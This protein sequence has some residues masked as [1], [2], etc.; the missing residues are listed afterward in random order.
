MKLD[1]LAFGAHPDDVELSCSGTIIKHVK[2]GKRVG[3]VDLTRGELGSRGNAET[4]K[5]E[6]EKASEILGIC[7]RENLGYRDGFFQ[8][9][10]EHQMG[11][12]R[13]IRKYRPK[14]V[15]CNARVDRH[16]DHGRAGELVSVA[17]FLSGL[18]KVETE[19]DGKKQ[20]HW[21]PAVV[22]H[23]VQD[24]YIKPNIVIDVSPFIE[25]KMQSILAYSSQFY[26]PGKPDEEP[27][28]PISSP[29]F[30]EAVKCKMI[31]F[32]RAINVHYGEGFTVERAPGVKLLTDL[33]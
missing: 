30:L 33:I 29:Q 3:V 24:R 25:L 2:A 16:P 18:R 21:R 11:V 27:Q 14:I 28:T 19:L 8:N 22:Y 12:I 6:A 26:K 4:R 17:A 1:I 15:L 32:G 31:D 23:Y 13:M 7:C 5:K 9:D 10:P 20:A